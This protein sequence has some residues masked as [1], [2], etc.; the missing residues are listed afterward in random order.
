MCRRGRDALQGAIRCCTSGNVLLLIAPTP[1]FKLNSEIGGLLLV[2]V[3]P[4]TVH[5]VF[6][7]TMVRTARPL[8][9]QPS[10]GVLRDREKDSSFLNVHSRSGSMIVISP[11][12]PGLRVPLG[13]RT[14]VAGFTVYIVIRRLMSIALV[15]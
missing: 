4:Y 12:A 13:R 2:L 3:V 8:S 9:S 7:P 1:A 6:P 10:N 14:R 11:S 15:P 5:T